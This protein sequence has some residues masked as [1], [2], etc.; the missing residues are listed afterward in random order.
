MAWQLQHMG[1]P[2]EV[3]QKGESNTFRNWFLQIARRCS[4]LT[5]ISAERKIIHGSSW[6]GWQLDSINN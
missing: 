2:K 1:M 5:P 6:V 3:H 4:A